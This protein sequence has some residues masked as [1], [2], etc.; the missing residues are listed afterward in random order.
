MLRLF[1]TWLRLFC[2]CLAFSLAVPS[3]AAAAPTVTM[4]VVDADVR[5]VL[6]GLA[7][8]G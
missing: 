3:L 2:L 7:T 1:P 8:I 5:D 6:T 4:S